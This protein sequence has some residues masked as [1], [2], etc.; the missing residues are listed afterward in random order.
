[1]NTSC[2]IC[3]GTGWLSRDLPISDPNFGKVF[4]CD[5][6]TPSIRETWLKNCGLSTSQLSSDIKQFE[7]IGEGTR[8]MMNA[9][10]IFLKNPVSILTI[11]GN[12]G[13]GKTTLAY[14]MTRKLI[15]SGY[16]T[17]YTTGPDMFNW[18]RDGYN[19][20]KPDETALRRMKMLEEIQILIIDELDKI[21][22]TEWAQR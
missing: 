10:K 15:E 16:Q 1:M 21:R 12:N 9:A 8:N 17:I 2:D 22:P 5:C 13:V 3:N 7:I 19:Q 6:Q 14:F 18:I 20:T 4:P 11:H